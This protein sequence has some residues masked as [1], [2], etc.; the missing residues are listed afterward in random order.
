VAIWLIATGL[1]AA[2]MLNPSLP[3]LPVF[4]ALPSFTS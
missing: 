1:L 4:C 2:D 3:A